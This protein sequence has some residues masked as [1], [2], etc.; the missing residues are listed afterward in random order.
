MLRSIGFMGYYLV[1]KKDSP[2]RQRN[3]GPDP[4]G[5]NI[6]ASAVAKTRE[7]VSSASHQP[8]N[9][10]DA[11]CKAATAK[12]KPGGVGSDSRRA[13]PVRFVWITRIAHKKL[14]AA[15]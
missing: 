6:W 4:I 10:S 5:K 13:S 1:L 15:P 2:R 14:K 7:R 3:F 9:M 12:R 8:R 11:A